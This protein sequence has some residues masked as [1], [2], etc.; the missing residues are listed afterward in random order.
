MNIESLF[1]PLEESIDLGK[2]VT[3]LKKHLE[4][5]NVKSYVMKV[6]GP[7]VGKAPLQQSEGNS[8][9]PRTLASLTTTLKEILSL[10]LPS[11]LLCSSLSTGPSRKLSDKQIQREASH[12]EALID[13]AHTRLSL[14]Q[15]LKIVLSSCFVSR[16]ALNIGIKTIS[17]S[18]LKKEMDKMEES[19]SYEELALLYRSV[20]KPHQA[21]THFKN[22]HKAIKDLS[23]TSQHILSHSSSFG[24]FS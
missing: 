18:F 4:R 14:A 13:D 22:A 23:S 8:S 12:P 5:A 7:A 21:L 2:S 10:P 17:S 15:V 24:Q 1:F 16:T 6:D 20:D 9:S 11:V 19:R 3:N